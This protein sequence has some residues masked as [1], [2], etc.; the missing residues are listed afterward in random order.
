MLHQPFWAAEKLY[1]Q[2]VQP[3]ALLYSVL[4]T[5]HVSPR[6]GSCGGMAGIISDLA[7]HK[8]IMLQVQ[9]HVSELR[10]AS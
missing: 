7:K 2:A 8:R 1:M 5:E 9:A 3:H 10:V 6:F 4:S